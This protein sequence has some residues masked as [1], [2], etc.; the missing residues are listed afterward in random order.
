MK[1]ITITISNE[2]IIK[3]DKI[4]CKVFAEFKESNPTQTTGISP[5]EEIGLYY[6]L[7]LNEVIKSYHEKPFLDLCLSCFADVIQKL[8]RADRIEY[9]SRESKSQEDLAFSTEIPFESEFLP[10][11][12]KYLMEHPALSSLFYYLKETDEHFEWERITN[13]DPDNPDFADH[14]EIEKIYYSWQSKRA[15]L[16]VRMLRAIKDNNINLSRFTYKNHGK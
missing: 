7:V 8:E 14:D 9:L 16:Y 6:K 3:I 11:L 2:T 12:N 5:L 13:I 1:K 15:V 4:A 10:L